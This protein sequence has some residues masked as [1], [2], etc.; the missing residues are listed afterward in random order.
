MICGQ[1]PPEETP[2]KNISD[3]Q[4]V[5]VLLHAILI[6]LSQYLPNNP[7]SLENPTFIDHLLVLPNIFSLGNSEWQLSVSATKSGKI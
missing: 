3:Y 2:L 4:T 7:G 1:W 6:Y 5:H